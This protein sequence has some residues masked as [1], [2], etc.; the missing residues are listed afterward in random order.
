MHPV[1]NLTDCSYIYSDYQNYFPLIYTCIYL[2]VH[3]N[4]YFQMV[5]A[6]KTL[7]TKFH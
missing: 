1:R 6:D 3:L 4:D 2:Y 7:D 5:T